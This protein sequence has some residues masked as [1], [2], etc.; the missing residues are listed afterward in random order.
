MSK[1]LR[2]RCDV[3]KPGAGKGNST[4]WLTTQD[5][6]NLVI[7]DSSSKAI[8]A[9]GTNQFTNILSSNT[10]FLKPGESLH[11]PNQRFRAAMQADGNFVI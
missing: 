1:P 7:Y 8:W 6:G 3:V 4:V 9:M 5:D 2:V 10:A 11:S